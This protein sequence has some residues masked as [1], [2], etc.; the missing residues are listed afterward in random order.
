MLICTWEDK[1]TKN[2]LLWI[3]GIIMYKEKQFIFTTS[4]KLAKIYEKSL[5][6]TG[7]KR[8]LT[9]SEMDVLVFLYTNK[10]KN[11][12]KDIAQYRSISKS[13][14]CK[15]VA[16]LTEKGLITS[17]QDQIDARALRLTLTQKGAGLAEEIADCCDRL[18]RDLCWGI[19]DSELQFFSNVQ[20]RILENGK[21][22][23]N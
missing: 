21:R 2:S 7:N 9:Q 19:S 18:C 4:W 8:S 11:T 5:Q 10:E 17:V 1:V 20:D 12:S 3:G 6:L 23:Y 16:S 13:L 22:K 15:S 14:I